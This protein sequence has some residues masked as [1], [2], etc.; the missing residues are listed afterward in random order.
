MNYRNKKTAL[1]LLWISLLIGAHD[2]SAYSQY[3]TDINNTCSNLGY[4]LIS[5][6]VSDSCVACHSDSQAKSAYSAGNYEYFC[7]APDVT[8]TCTDADGD[9]YYAEGES[10]GTLADFND[11]DSTAYPG[12]PEVC[13][14]GVDNDGDGLIDA[15]DSD[16]VDC[17]AAC[18]DMDADGYATEGGS[19]GA[20]DCDDNN[21]EVNPGAVEVCSDAIDNNCNGLTDT[22]DMNA[23]NCPLDCTDNDEDGYS[24]EGGSCGAVDCD[25]NN[26]EIN[27]AALEICDDGIDNN[28]NSL[29]DNAD[30][31]CQSDDAV[32]DSC[33]MPWWRSKHKHNHTLDATCESSDVL[34]DDTRD[35]VETGDDTDTSDIDNV[36]DDDQSSDDVE[37]DQVKGQAK[38][39][40]WFN[41]R[42][43]RNRD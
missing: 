43:W 16:A 3:T 20:I 1:L 11:N 30:A 18:T 37:S 15:A 36:G 4:D 14:D 17:V 6:Y 42:S 21:A 7:P 24:I 28:C 26:A 5:E 25:D 13:N 29:V 34:D 22:A 8:T 35:D 27:P 31:V 39:R 38:F 40:E 41:T 10:C 12:A 2:A 33:N 9:N 32:E 23:V 19:C